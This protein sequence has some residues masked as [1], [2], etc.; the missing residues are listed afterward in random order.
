MK[1]KPSTSKSI[2]IEKEDLIQKILKYENNKRFG[3]PIKQSL[4]FKHTRPQLSKM[5]LEQLETI[6]HRIRTFLNT[7]NMDEIFEHMARHTAKGYEDIVTGIGYDINGFSDLLLSNPAFW[8]AFERWKIEQKIP[9]V[10]PSLQLG[11]I[12][13][14]TTYVAHLQS[15]RVKQKQIKNK[16][17]ETKKEKEMKKKETNDKVKVT[18][19]KIGDTL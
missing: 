11:Y 18:K 4:G 6:L 17:T 10:P 19:M 16:K 5:S 9:Q 13:A 15:S 12:I 3:A 1:K 2:A 14:S 7:R 8:D